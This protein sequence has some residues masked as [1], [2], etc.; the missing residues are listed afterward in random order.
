MESRYKRLGDYIEESDERN[1][2]LKV[3]LLLG[4]SI[5]KKF[6]KSIANTVGTDFRN[7]KIVKKGQF[8]YG[9]VTSRNGDKI[10]IALLEEEICIVSSSYTV[11]KIVK[12]GELMQEYLLLLFK[13]PEFDRYARY[14]SWG[15]AREVFSWDD[16][17]NSTFYIPAIDVQK[18]I[19]RQ[20]N[21]FRSRIDIIS[22]INKQLDKMSLE[23]WEKW[24]LNGT[25]NVV[26]INEAIDIKYGKGLPVSD[27]KRKGYPVFG[28]NGIIGFYDKFI[29][30]L[31]QILVSCRGAAS[32]NIVI[33][34]PFSYVT[35]NSLVFELKDR[36]YFYFLQQYFTQNPLNEH[37]TGS[38]Q[39]QITIENLKDVIVPYPDYDEINELSRMLETIVKTKSI[40]SSEI[41]VL[42][43]AQEE[44][45]LSLV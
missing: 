18:K 42:E 2:D 6:I 41:L 33:S 36:R 31:P 24:T 26:N 45:I 17:C 23:L 43:K 3:D 37:A 21:V 15:S 40:N 30:E 19:I 32:G 27:L 39:P 13:I 1:E 9:P 25:N 28:G 16:L 10:S 5:E 7:Y 4:V 44:F 11:F 34:L 8:A 22:N 20:Y 12:P 29:Y 35:S 38:A 14:N